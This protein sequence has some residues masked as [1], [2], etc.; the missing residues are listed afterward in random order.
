METAAA[1]LERLKQQVAALSQQVTRCKDQLAELRQFLTVEERDDLEG[2][3]KILHIRCWG[4]TLCNPAKPNRTQGLLMGSETGPFLA[5][6]GSDEKARITL[7]AEDDT[8]G[9]SFYSKDLKE[10]VTI[11]VD[12]PAGRGEVGVFEAGQPRAILKATPQG[13]C[14]SVV[15]DDGKVRGTMVSSASGADV[16]LVNPDM[17]PV[18]KLTSET[19][20]GGFICVNA[21]N[22]KPAVALTPNEQ[23]GSVL[24][25]HRQGG[26]GCALTT[27]AQGGA[28]Q[29]SASQ[30][31]AG[32]TLMVTD[33]GAMVSVSNA[34]GV[35]VAELATDNQRGSVSLSDAQGKERLALRQSDQGPFLALKTGEDKTHVM[36]SCFDGQGELDL[37]SPEGAVTALKTHKGGS[38]L[39]MT[40]AQGKLTLYAGHLDGKTAVHLQPTDEENAAVSLF[41]QADGEGAVMVSAKDGYRRAALSAAK[42]GGQL[43][44]FNDL[45]LER[46]LVACVQDGGA[47]RLSWGGTMSVAALARHEGGAVIVNDAEGKPA[48]TLP[49][50]ADD[51]EDADG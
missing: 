15:H 49:P 33:S 23:G 36:L 37:E 51:G 26:V 40:N 42:D 24:V 20:K 19:E 39:S 12:E 32:A 28:V 13:G 30:G 4:L 50:M 6:W 10:A 38:S 3:P 35:R 43:L 47:V 1:E 18:V 22:G 48:A 25:M 9:C 11:R 2:S 45:G 16:L 41:T 7:S 8:A 44:L 14:V 21:P 17:K 29:V 31:K 34:E 27:A 46:A 5:L